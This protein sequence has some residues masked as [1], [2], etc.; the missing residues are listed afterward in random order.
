MLYEEMDEELDEETIKEREKISALY[1]EMCFGAYLF[2]Y[3]CPAYLGED[4]DSQMAYCKAKAGALK[5]VS[6]VYGI[7]DEEE[8]EAALEKL[9]RESK[10]EFRTGFNFY[11]ADANKI[12]MTSRRILKY[13][14]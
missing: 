8:C 13:P 4:E 12:V 3:Y 1:S 7:K 14:N 9:C 5:H 11:L 2:F 6:R 10:E